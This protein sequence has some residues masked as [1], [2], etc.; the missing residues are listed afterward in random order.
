ML[1]LEPAL[2][3]EG[4]ILRGFGGVGEIH[5]TDSDAVATIVSGSTAG[6]SNAA[7][8]LR[9]RSRFLAR[10]YTPDAILRNDCLDKV[11]FACPSFF[12]SRL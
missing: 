11:Q 3:Q 9:R 2:A 7:P 6:G 1:Q 12:H 5:G 8:Q 10:L 4:A